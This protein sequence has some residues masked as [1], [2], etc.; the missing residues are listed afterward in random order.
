MACMSCMLPAAPGAPPNR[1]SYGP[2]SP[3]IVIRR[4]EVRHVAGRAALKPGPERAVKQTGQSVRQRIPAESPQ[5]TP[6]EHPE[7]ATHGKPFKP[8]LKPAACCWRQL[9][10]IVL[11]ALGQARA[12]IH[13]E[14]LAEAVLQVVRAHRGVGAIAH[15]IGG[16]IAHPGLIDRIHR[17]MIPSA[18][19]SHEAFEPVLSG[20]EHIAQR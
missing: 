2:A 11:E 20:S 5:D 14:V 19:P 1:L 10:V 3:R 7:R 4:A 18:D 16:R 12:G 13:A 17:G 15:R 9:A 6:A 8:A